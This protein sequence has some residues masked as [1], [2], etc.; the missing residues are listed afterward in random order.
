MKLLLYLCLVA[1]GPLAAADAGAPGGAPQAPAKPTNR[2]AEIVTKALES[3]SG[4][5]HGIMMSVDA[6][7]AATFATLM[8]GL[9][10][11]FKKEHATAPADTSVLVVS[12]IG[13]VSA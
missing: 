13:D 10:A 4:P 3:P 1:T 12:L 6:P 5:T 9:V 11:A 7:D 2:L 8:P